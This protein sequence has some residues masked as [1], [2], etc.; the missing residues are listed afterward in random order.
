MRVLVLAVAATLLVAPAAAAKGVSK[1]EV[2]GAT[3]CAEV[4]ERDLEALMTGGSPANPPPGA[5]PWY[6]VRS[7]VR[8]NREQG[9]DFEPFTF[10]DAFVP[11]AGLLR[12]RS[13]GAG[14]TWYDV[15][16]RYERAM[17]RASAGLAPRPAARLRGL[18]VAPV[19]ARVHKVF[20]AP[21]AVSAG[22]G[23]PW[24]LIALGGAVAALLALALP[25]RRLLIAHRMAGDPS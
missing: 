19:E 3:R 10:Q 17:R 13:E 21:V 15:N 20:P 2:C 22:G 9:E 16:D 4:S 24:A 23:T 12:V 8:P 18:D 11:S 7:T 1:M 25:L 5:A 6:V 14:F